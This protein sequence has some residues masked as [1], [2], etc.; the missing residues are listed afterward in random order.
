MW[1]EAVQHNSPPSRG[2][3]SC[4]SVPRECSTLWLTQQGWGNYQEPVVYRP[5][6]RQNTW[7]SIQHWLDFLR[8][9]ARRSRRAGRR[10]PARRR[11]WRQPKYVNLYS[12]PVG[13]LTCRN[14]WIYSTLDGLLTC[15][16]APL[17]QSGPTA[18]GT[19]ERLA[20]AE[21]A[22]CC[23]CPRW[24]ERSA[25][26]G[27]MAPTSGST[28]RKRSSAANCAIACA[29]WRGLGWTRVLYLSI[30]LSKCFYKYVSTHLYLYRSI[31]PSIHLY[32]SLDLSSYICIHIHI[33]ILI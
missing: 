26:R 24:D 9:W 32:R 22:H 1:R 23:T 5:L 17:A 33:H 7:I 2:Q 12:T 27:A 18:A 4:G 25:A 13:L 20:T 15:V 31:Y 10:P 21:S 28:W 14:T 6:T 8:V 16:S 19:K 11:G 29:T 30:Y 3:A